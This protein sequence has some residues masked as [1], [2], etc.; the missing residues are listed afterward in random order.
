MLDQLLF[1]EANCLALNE[2]TKEAQ[3]QGRSKSRTPDASP[4]KTAT[5]TSLISFPNESVRMSKM[6]SS[7][8]AQ[9]YVE[10]EQ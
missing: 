1:E 4:T 6:R 8:D 2:F 3:E 7:V 9:S 10:N 5:N